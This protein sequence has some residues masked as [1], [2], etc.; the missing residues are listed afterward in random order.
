MTGDMRAIVKETKGPGATMRRMPIP[1]IGPKDVLIKVKATAICGTDVHIYTWD[2][3]SQSRVN[4]PRIFGHEFCGNVVE[5]G[6]QVKSTVPG[7]FVSAETHIICGT[8]FHC[9]TGAGHICQ[10]VEILG[11]DRDGCFAEY[12]AVPEENVWKVAENIP[13]EVAAIHD[14][15]GNAVHTVFSADV[16]AAKVAIIGVG[17]IG[18]AAIPIARMAGA[19][20]VFVTEINEY[21]LNL[22][23]ELGADLAVNSRDE[24]PVRRILDATGGVGVDV[25]LEM[26]G[27]A[28]AINQGLAVLRKG[29]EMSLLGIPSRPVELDLAD[30]VIFKGATL[31]G[32]SGREMFK[33]WYRLAS[34]LDA[35][36][37]VT[38]I[39]THEF[40]LDEFETAMN[41]AISGNCGKIILYP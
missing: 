35:G 1:E 2:P 14:P 6:S 37:D 34:L 28:K 16:S 40:P 38:P 39:I 21:R 32:I 11:V 15:L 41:L 22:G 27:N 25:V 5:V 9:R 3:W 26:S 30:G 29:G 24:D 17:P 7:D 19:T 33:T 8:C 13:I 18:L 36:L 4:P 10:D 31:R 23:R 12:V 20:K